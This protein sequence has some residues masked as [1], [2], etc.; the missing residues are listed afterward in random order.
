M[1][2]KRTLSSRELLDRL[3]ESAGN[4]CGDDSLDDEVSDDEIRRHPE[5][6]LND[7]IEF[8]KRAGTR[9]RAA[10]ERARRKQDLED[11]LEYIEFIAEKRARQRQHRENRNWASC[12]PV[13]AGCA[14]TCLITAGLVKGQDIAQYITNNWLHANQQQSQP[15]QPS[16]P[17]IAPVQPIQPVQPM[18]PV[19]T[20]NTWLTSVPMV[21]DRSN[22]MQRVDG[23]TASRST[24]TGFADSQSMT[25]AYYWTLLVSNSGQQNQEARMR[26]VLPAGATLSRATLW[27]NGTPQEA[28]FSTT[29]QVTAAYT[30]VRDGREQQRFLS[31]DPLVITQESPGHL[32]VK[33]APVTPGGQPL[34]LRLGFTAP[35]IPVST[36]AASMRLPQITE[37]NFEVRGTQDVH[38]QSATSVWSNESEVTAIPGESGFLLRGNLQE[39]RLT[40]LRV[41][42][43]RNGS[44][45][46][47]T[48]ATHSRKGTFIVATMKPDASGRMIL[49]LKKTTTRPTCRMI[50]SEPAAVRLSTLWA[51]GQVE[52]SVKRG[53]RF[54]ANELARIFRIVSSVSGAT[55][56]EQDSD[57][58]NQGLSRDQYAIYDRRAVSGGGG[59]GGS[60]FDSFAASGA[61]PSLQPSVKSEAITLAP[62]P[63]APVP[64]AM[65]TVMEMPTPVAPEAHRPAMAN[66]ANS[67]SR[68]PAL[69]GDTDSAEILI[70]DEDLTTGMP[71]DKTQPTQAQADTPV[72]AQTEKPVPAQTES[73]A[74]VQALSKQIPQFLLP[75]VLVA[76][77]LFAFSKMVR[78]LPEKLLARFKK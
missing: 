70:A 59:G 76:A 31:H 11:D 28:A 69:S 18:R 3:Y 12:S 42:V 68:K 20:T 45:Q 61:M 47:A 73:Q 65:P 30:W 53:D 77:M 36:Q 60:V 46:F 25:A 54:N 32:L 66:P 64:V 63:H 44:D 49:S 75:I 7:T 41:N 24:I 10:S 72:T 37:S 14:L 43:A 8:E 9:S 34:Q 2:K 26:I 35:L 19:L 52:A 56:L 5:A 57:Y 4:D 29:E 13:L 21:T 74:P 62:S 23:L 22:S 78:A 15:V 58:L 16:L 67:S 55:V 39:D 33:A 40:S 48:R 38:L 50:D 1:N 27:V 6:P 17:P 71:A 51:Y